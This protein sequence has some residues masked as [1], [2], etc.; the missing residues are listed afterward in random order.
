MILIKNIT[1]VTQNSE[2]RIIEDG[3]ILI[4]GDKIADVGQSAKLEK[5]YAKAKNKIIDGRGKVAIPGL[6]NAHTHAAMALLRGYADDM[7]LKDW[8][9]KKIWPA[10]MKFKPEDIYQG[11]KLACQEM[12]ASGTTTFNNMYWQPAQ[13]IKAAQE[14][15]L[16]DF[17]GLT[18]LDSGGMDVG[19]AQI[20]GEFERLK[21]KINGNIKLV[22]TPHSIYAVSEKT[23]RWCRKF[24]DDNDLLLHIHLSETEDEVKTC[25]EKHNCRP[26]EYL[27]K[28]GF[29]DSNVV[30]AHC[31]WLNEKEIEILAKRNVSV[32]HCPVSNLKLASG[33]MPFGKLLAAGVNVALG[34]D[35]PA[36]NN[37]LD[38]FGEMKIAALIHKWEERNPAAADAQIILDSA[39]INGAKALEMEQKIGS[40]DIGK[41]ADIVMLDFNKPRLKPLHNV[42]SHL[43]YAAQSGDVEKVI[44]GGQVLL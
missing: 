17:V 42:V 11:T 2:R 10:E 21:N 9:E 16:R 20:A 43:V 6:I 37:S 22:L 13:E 23:L 28:I 7:P 34:T 33:V 44:I 29:L 27:E 12:L 38:M 40:L 35:G 24:A 30:A 15:G 8:L 41:E 1:I 26:V 32:A 14:T 25:L 5:K 39:T 19:P 18:A 36:S 3:A 31:C 4:E